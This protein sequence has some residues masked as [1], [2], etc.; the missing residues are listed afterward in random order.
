[1]GK[2]SVAV[3]DLPRPGDPSSPDVGLVVGHPIPSPP[4]LLQQCLLPSTSCCPGSLLLCQGS[5]QVMQV[6]GPVAPWSN[7]QTL[8]FSIRLQSSHQWPHLTLPHTVELPVRLG[9]GCSIFICQLGC[10]S[11]NSSSLS[12]P[13]V[14]SGS[15]TDDFQFCWAVTGSLGS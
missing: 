10:S 15:S 4:L 8:Q 13:G 1:M 9:K 14:E 3:E 12:T 11:L 7:H 2:L 6:S 5:Y